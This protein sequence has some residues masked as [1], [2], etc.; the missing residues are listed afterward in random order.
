MVTH[1]TKCE[2]DYDEDD[3]GA[4]EIKTINEDNDI[5][6]IEKGSVWNETTRH[7]I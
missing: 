6:N 1:D 4:N 7:K 3:N 2:C 5:K